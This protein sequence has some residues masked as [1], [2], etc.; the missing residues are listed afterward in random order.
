M[1]VLHINDYSDVKKYNDLIKKVP[2]VTLFYADWC[3]HCQELKPKWRKLEKS[4][5][6][7]NDKMVLARVN[8]SVM[9]EIEGDKD[10]MGFPTIYYLENGSKKSEFKKE[11]SLFELFNFISEIRPSKKR[12]IMDVYRNTILQKGGKKNKVTK[13]KQSRKHIR[14]RKQMKTI[15]NKRK[16]RT[17]RRKYK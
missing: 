7:L 9:S 3:G 13:T 2:M 6:Q 12:E 14:R 15:K 10:I 8:N 5:Q 11:R 1:K 17:N 4:L 16:A